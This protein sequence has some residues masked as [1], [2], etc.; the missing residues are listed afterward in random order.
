MADEP[1]R[2][3]EGDSGETAETNFVALLLSLSL[4]YSFLEE[5]Q[6]QDPFCVDFRDQILSYV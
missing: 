2:I 6:K 3:F 1:S 5:L 4:L